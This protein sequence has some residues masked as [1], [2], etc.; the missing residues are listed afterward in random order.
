MNKL[1]FIKEETSRY[2]ET[3]D[4]IRF[5]FIAFDCKVNL[6]TGECLWRFEP[7]YEKSKWKTINDLCEAGEVV[8]K[9]PYEE[10]TINLGHPREID[11]D[12]IIKE[13]QQHGFNVTEEAIM[14]NFD[15]WKYDYKSGYRDDSKNFFLFSPCGCN[16]FKLCAMTLHP[17][18][19]D[20]Q[21]TYFC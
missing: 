6:K 1:E 12:S 7:E 19:A 21:Y 3:K 4:G 5:D 10:Y 17:T 20:W 11:V 14:H 16:P 15:A 2:F 9:F 18:C 13:F 8:Q